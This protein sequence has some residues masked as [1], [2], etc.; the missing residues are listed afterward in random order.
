M[1][2]ASFC[3]KGLLVALALTAATPFDASAASVSDLNELV[4]SASTEA[5]DFAQSLAPGWNLGNS[6][7]CH[8]DGM[9]YE[10][11][12]KNDVATIKAFKTAK[13]A[14]FKAVRIPVTWM[15][16]IG[17]A[18]AYAIDPAYMK[19]VAEVVGYAKKLGLKAIVN[20][21]HDGFG[22]ETDPVKASY[23]WLNVPAAAKDPGRHAETMREITQVWSQIATHFKDEG[24]W[25]VFETFNELQDGQWGNGENRTDGGAQYR[26][27]N[28]WN[29]T[30]VNAIR[31]AGGENAHRFIGVPGFVTQPGLTIE[32][33][34]LPKDSAKDRLMVA[35]HAYDPWDYAGSGK[36]SEWGHTGKDVVPDK[37]DEKTYVGMLDALYNAYIV[38]GIPVYFGEY[39]CV[40]RADERAEA[41]RKYYLEYICKAMHDRKMVGFFWDNGYHMEGDDAFGLIDHTTGKYIAN[42]REIVKIIV[43]A[44]TCTKPGYTLESIYERAPK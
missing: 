5:L 23:H 3:L 24:E 37:A 18:P 35:V 12:W 33:L 1:K 19:R 4:A 9:A 38:K 8:A 22:A 40:H 2:R 28:E 14:G 39:G 11:Y 6:L 32:H 10:A 27:V 31:S 30:A 42:S 21:H 34:V 25:L 15:G 16:H 20:I 36:Y 44:S 43:K 7:D 41:F 26:V 29:Q 17:P 13:A